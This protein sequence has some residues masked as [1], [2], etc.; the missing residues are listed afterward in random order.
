MDYTIGRFNYRQLKMLEQVP[1]EEKAWHE[2][3]FRVGNTTY[4]YFQ[5][6]RQAEPTEEEFADWFTSLPENTREEMKSQGFQI[7]KKMPPFIWYV[8]NK[9]DDQMDPWMRQHL[10]EKDYQWWRSKITVKETKNN[11]I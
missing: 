4:Y 8:R 10:A 9:R 5:H 1:Q 2:L 6:I 3:V 11:H 7:C